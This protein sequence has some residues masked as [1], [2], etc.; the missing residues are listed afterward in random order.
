[1]PA[2]MWNDTDTPLAYFISSR[3]Y[4]TWL[5][6]DRRGSID[7]LH[8][9][10]R[11]PYIPPNKQWLNYNQQQLRASPFILQSS[12]RTSIGAAIREAC[13]FRKWQLWA[14]NV[15]INHVH[16]VVAAGKKPEL[17]LNAFKANAT[18]RLRKDACGVIRSV[19]AQTK[20]AS[21]DSG[22]NA[23]LPGRSTTCF[24]ARAISCQTLMSEQSCEPPR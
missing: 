11:S 5:H 8:N 10:Y 14:L 23:A 18:R 24:M 3:S 7:R 21:D 4:G 2:S 12:H 15:R 9:Q 19:H 17:V 16:T 22:T 6:G 13:D 20:A 1:M